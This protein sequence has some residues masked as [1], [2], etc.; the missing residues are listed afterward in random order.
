MGSWDA[1]WPRSPYVCTVDVEAGGP[2]PR[3]TPSAVVTPGVSQVASV[4]GPLYLER[5]LSRADFNRSEADFLP[6][7]ARRPPT[8]P[9]IA[10]FQWPSSD[11]QR[12]GG[13]GNRKPSYPL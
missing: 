10:A 1:S 2:K 11:F 13:Y 7:P 12:S 4:R 9:N 5:L 3:E 8:R 6:Y